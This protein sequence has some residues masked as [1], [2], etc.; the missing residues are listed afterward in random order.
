MKVVR[1]FF[2][3]VGLL[4][5]GGGNDGQ[6]QVGKLVWARGLVVTV[7]PEKKNAKHT[8]RDLLRLCV[9]WVEDVC[10]QDVGSRERAVIGGRTCGKG[11]CTRV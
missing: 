8:S 2:W 4:G 1:D 9:R 3:G 7:G 5:C 10:V 6:V 11:R